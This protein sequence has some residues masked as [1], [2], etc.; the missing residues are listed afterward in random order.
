M[1]FVDNASELNPSE[2]SAESAVVTTE[3]PSAIGLA[4]APEQEHSEGGESNQK[5]NSSS[6]SSVE[7][8]AGGN[9]YLNSS[10]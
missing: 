8:N 6:A 9:N 2:K 7:L 1:I 10:D 5:L 3:T 4:K